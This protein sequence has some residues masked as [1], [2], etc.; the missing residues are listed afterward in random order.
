M[1]SQPPTYTPAQYLEAGH[2]AEMAGARERAAQYYHYLAEAFAD[3][4]E[5]EAARAGLARLGYAPRQQPQQH[6]PSS[7]THAAA[8]TGA[9]GY[10]SPSEPF[11]YAGGYP[12][13][14]TTRPH[15]PHA[16]QS[17]HA[18]PHRPQVQAH[19]PQTHMPQAQHTE[20]G[21]GARIRLGELSGQ[22][23]A[24]RPHPAQSD[25][26]GGPQSAQSVRADDRAHDGDGEDALR[27]P[28]VVARR[29]REIAEFDEGL[30]FEKQY[31]GARLL[32]HVVTWLGWIVTAGGL[33]LF[34]LGFAGIP[35][36][37][38]GVIIGLP[39][40]VV[41]GFAEVVAGLALALGGQVAL[42]TFDQAQAMREIGIMLRAR[43]DL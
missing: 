26:H 27:L 39:G 20:R 31:R 7:Q 12:Q 41:I 36:S 17:P 38:A 10:R 25:V 11:G 3:T 6:S 40:G 29:A 22:P 15:H 28:E 21:M 14:A 30:H 2:R 9:E 19:A 4:P 5:G 42:A 33:A 32:A 35:P 18:A 34:V 23:L 24:T 13:S 1:S 43:V 16:E 8:D 37:L